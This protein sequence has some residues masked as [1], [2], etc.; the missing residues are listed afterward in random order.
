MSLGGNFFILLLSRV[1]FLS[2]DLCLVLENSQPLLFIVNL[3]YFDD[4]Y[5]VEKDVCLCG[6]LTTVGVGYGKWM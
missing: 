5:I 2:E 3:F 6:P 1:N 4:I